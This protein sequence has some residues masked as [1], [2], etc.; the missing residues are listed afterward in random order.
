VL[1]EFEFAALKRILDQSAESH[2]NMPLRPE[3]L[4]SALQPLAPWPEAVQCLK[5]KAPGGR[6]PH[7]S[8]SPLTMRESL[9][10]QAYSASCFYLS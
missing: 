10:P 1:Y 8:S 5:S 3:L 4:N 6:L 9:A 7:P 2:A